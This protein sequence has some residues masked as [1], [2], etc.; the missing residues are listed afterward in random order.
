MVTVNKIMNIITD[1][2][3][4]DWL[5]FMSYG[6]LTVHVLTNYGLQLQQSGGVWRLRDNLFNIKV[7]R[8]YRLHGLIN[9]LVYASS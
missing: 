8:L 1:L 3:K 9:K 5:K 2:Y 4:S 7:T 6:R